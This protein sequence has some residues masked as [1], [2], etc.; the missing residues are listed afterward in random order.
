MA[1]PTA[2]TPHFKFATLPGGSTED[3]IRMKYPRMH[4]YMQ[5]YNKTS[6]DAGIRALLAG[7]V[8]NTRNADGVLYIERKTL[9]TSRIADEYHVSQ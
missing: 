6:V 4:R 3:N 8:F 9:R 2:V 1:N 7:Y 5:K